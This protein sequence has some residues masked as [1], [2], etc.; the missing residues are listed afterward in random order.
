MAASAPTRVDTAAMLIVSISAG[1]W[2]RNRPGRL[3]RFSQASDSTSDGK[4]NTCGRPAQKSPALRSSAKRKP[5]AMRATKITS[6]SPPY[7]RLRRTI[8]R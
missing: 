7:I 4:S 6:S 8:S 5:E 1:T 2:S 3:A